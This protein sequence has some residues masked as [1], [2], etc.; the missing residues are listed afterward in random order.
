RVA[1]RAQQLGDRPE[2]HQDQ[3]GRFQ[4]PV[5]AVEVQLAAKGV[6]GPP[7]DPGSDGRQAAPPPVGRVPPLPSM[8]PFCPRT[9]DRRQYRAPRARAACRLPVAW[10]VLHTIRSRMNFHEYQAKQLIAEYGL[11]VR[12][13]L[14]ALT[15]EEAVEDAKS[16]PGDQ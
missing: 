13:E 1:R 2:D 8:A 16:I 14:T 15:A 5:Q 3:D 4:Q 11:A 7:V 12:A 9:P 6:F 10:D